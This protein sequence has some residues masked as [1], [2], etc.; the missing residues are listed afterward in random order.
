MTTRP[1]HYMFPDAFPTVMCIQSSEEG[2]M[3]KKE[4]APPSFGM[5]QFLFAIVLA[6]VLF[7]LGESMVQHFTGHPHHSARTYPY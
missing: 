5:G 1:R 3:D 7:I 4:P 6:V 2:I